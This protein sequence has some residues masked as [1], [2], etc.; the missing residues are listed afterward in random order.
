MNRNRAFTLIELLIVIAIIALLA[1]ILVPA[2]A[3][4]ME[5][6]RRTSCAN[7]LKA[8]AGFCLSYSSVNAGGLPTGSLGDVA[9]ALYNSSPFEFK[10]WICPSAA[11]RDVAASSIGG[12][13]SGPNSSYM[14][15]AGYTN[16]LRVKTPPASTPFWMDELKSTIVVSPD[17]NHANSLAVNIAFLDGHVAPYKGPDAEAI[18]VKAIGIVQ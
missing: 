17:D 14:Y 2:V 16:F 13:N 18:I 3:K 11:R 7:N 9:T 1:S 6:S 4:A 15:A 8:L 5:A 12:F 10:T